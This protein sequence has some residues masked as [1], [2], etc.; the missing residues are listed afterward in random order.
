V[1]FAA[2][3][4]GRLSEHLALPRGLRL[5]EYEL[6]LF[7]AFWFVVGM[8]DE[9]AI[10]LAYVWLRVFRGYRTQRL[11][12][13]GAAEP[14][15][16][17]AAVFIPA[18]HEAAV[19]GATISH[20]LKVWPQAELRLY[21]GCYANDADTLLA[22]MAAA[23]SDH[24]LRLVVHDQTG[25]STKGDCLN[26]LYQALHCDEARSGQTAHMVVIHDAEDMVHPQALALMAAALDQADFVQIPV[27]PE[28]ER[29]AWWIAGHYLD[30]FTESHARAMV[31][32]DALGA[33]LPA[34]GVGCAFARAMLDRLSRFHLQQ[35]LPGPFAADCLTEDYELGLLVAHHGGQSRFLRVRD[36]SGALIATRSCF[37]VTL[38][39]AVRQKTRWLHGI[40][41]QSWDRLGW[42]GNVIDIWMALRDRRGPLAALILAI[43]Y[44]LL[45]LSPLLEAARH[46]GLVGDRLASP[47]LYGL[48]RLCLFAMIWRALLRLVFTTREYG[49]HEGLRAVLRIP[50]ANV[51]AIMSARRAVFAYL[52]SLAGKRLVWD[53]TAH[54]DHPAFRLASAD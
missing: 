19:I 36:A 53:K 20:M 31:V 15:R 27:R 40:A 6:T 25:P 39:E 32:R 22:V 8:L 54:H 14:L 23:G 17:P 49:L 13:N 51:I 26:R 5:A 42:Q 44:F 7:A 33:A 4:V 16:G 3:N 18:W 43:A 46:W 28:P 47:Q 50:V 2:H 10:D 37:P 24:R 41:F 1:E 38:H 12:A 9:L 34:A 30:E 45:L 35:A 11:S 48:A 52:R 29:S 21:V